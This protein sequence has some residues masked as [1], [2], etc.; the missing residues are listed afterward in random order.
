MNA[1]EWKKRKHGKDIKKREKGEKETETWLKQEE[2]RI[3][4]IKK[5]ADKCDEKETSITCKGSHRKEKR[6]RH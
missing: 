5:K 1:D 3:R 2:M 4:I 6:D